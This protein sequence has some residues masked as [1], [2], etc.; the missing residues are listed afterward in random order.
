MKKLILVALVVILLTSGLLVGCGP[1]RTQTYNFTDFTRVEV[2]YAFQVEVVQSNS[3]SISITAREDLFNFIQV[4]KEGETLKI[5][6]TQYI[7]GTKKAEITMP[8]LRA[9]NLSGA[10]KG[11]IKGFIS[12]DDFTLDLSGASRLDGDLTAGDVD[13]H[14]SGASAVELDGS[15]QDIDVDTSGA[16]HVKL[17]DFS[18]RNADVTLRGASNGTVNLSGKLDADLSGAS[19]LEYVGEPTLGTINTSGSSTLRKK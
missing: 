14:V 4:S 6:L 3:Y 18:V 1:V 2:G 5:G 15:A 13:F 7:R 17:A 9:I 16:S 11:T 12:S 8:D 10:A 19:H